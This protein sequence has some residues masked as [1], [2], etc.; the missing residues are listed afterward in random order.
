MLVKLYQ[1]ED[2][3]F[4]VQ[5]ENGILQNTERPLNPNDSFFA[6]KNGGMS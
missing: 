2:K 1:N 3:R 4:G 6:R 5:N